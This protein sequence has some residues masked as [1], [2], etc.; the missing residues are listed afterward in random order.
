MDCYD[1]KILS[2]KDFQAACIPYKGRLMSMVVLLPREVDGLAKLERQLTSQGLQ[3]W[4]AELDR[5]PAL[6]TELFMPKFKLETG[7][8]LVAP[9]KT[10]GMN[11]AFDVSG[12]ADFRGMGW[13]KGELYISQVKHKAFVEVNEEGTE[14]SGATAVEMSKRSGLH[15]PVF[16][17][18]HPFLF[19]I[20]DNTTGSILFMGRMVDPR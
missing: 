17:A 11:D 16:R 13:P 2:K 5:K 19:V 1:R 3:N 18:D 12:E 10:L 15:D 9:C 6:A 20:R 7:Y 14:A 8:G 4:L